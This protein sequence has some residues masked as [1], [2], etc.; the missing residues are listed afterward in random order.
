MPSPR[1]TAIQFAHQHR[2]EYLAALSDLIRIPSVS[3]NP[4][5]AND[6]KKA[7]TWLAT[8]L[9][10]L[11]I[12]HVQVFPTALHPII[13]GDWLHAGADKPTILI[14][15]HYDVQPPDPEEKWETPPF[16]PVIRGD[17]LYARGASDMKGQLIAVLSALQAIFQSGPLPVNIKFILEGEEEIGS[18]S[19]S[20]YLHEK[21][22]LLSSSL[23]LNP[24]AGM[25]APDVPTIVYSL[26]G[27]AY[28]EIHVEGPTIDLHSGLFGGGIQNPAQVL[29]DLISG[30]RDEHGKIL[31]PGFYDHVKPIT[32]EEHAQLA[33]LPLNDQFYMERSGAPLLWGEE[34]YTPAERAGRRP[35]LDVNGIIAGFTG[36]GSKTVIPS[37][38]MAKISMRL[39]PDQN[40]DEVYQQLISYLKNKAPQTVK[41]EVVRFSSGPA[42]QTDLE[43]PATK[44]MFAALKTVWG[45]DPVYKPEG[46]SIPIAAEM[47]EVLGIQSVLT[48]FGLPEDAIHSPNERLHLP[49]WYNGI[50]ALIHFF[51]NLE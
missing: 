15:G 42:V 35:T 14:Y 27:L 17:R 28:F 36:K 32:A 37:H 34:G 1:E 8:K 11:G 39:V 40:P 24:D 48:G 16:E 6:V 51:Y 22:A 44:A 7:A 20:V 5:N 46:G 38:A 23:A 31:L 33:R 9:T 10:D 29:C 25:I 43:L 26:R 45:K 50:D 12:E 41:W 3:T 2:D 49:T 21:K 4:E 13:Y 18:P 30:M 19:M 47:Q